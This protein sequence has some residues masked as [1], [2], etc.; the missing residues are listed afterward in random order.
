MHLFSKLFKHVSVFIQEVNGRFCNT[1]TF[2]NWPDGNPWFVVFRIVTGRRVLFTFAVTREQ[3]F[4]ASARS[5][6]TVGLL[7]LVIDNLEL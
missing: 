4:L 6:D 2:L 1:D 3:L 7:S 5:M